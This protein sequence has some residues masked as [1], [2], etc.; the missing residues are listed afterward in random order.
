MGRE[1]KL[2]MARKKNKAQGNKKTFEK[3]IEKRDEPICH[4][5]RNPDLAEMVETKDPKKMRRLLYQYQIDL[6]NYEKQKAYILW[7]N[8]PVADVYFGKIK[9]AETSAAPLKE[10]LEAKRNKK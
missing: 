5:R 4:H 9:I 10:K 1:K 2:R 6:F 7:P 3:R 8:N